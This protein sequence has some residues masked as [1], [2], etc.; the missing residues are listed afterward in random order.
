MP[1]LS[2]AM[3]VKN[4]AHRLGRCLDSVKGLADEL[5]VVDT[6]STDGTVALA[7]A[8]GARI[9]HFKWCDDFAAARNEAL[10]LC[11]GTWI[12]VLDA[13]ERL[14]PA[15]LPRIRQTLR[16]PQA[17]GFLLTMRNHLPS[18]AYVG[19]HGGARPDPGGC[20]EAAGLA[21]ITEL[22]ELRLFRNHPKVRYRG[23]IH[24][25]IEPS[26]EAQGWKAVPL[27][28][29]IH[30]LGKADPTHELAKQEAYFRM[31][32]QEAEDHPS[33]RH[34]LY[35]L[36]Q[37]AAMVKAWEACAEAALGFLRLTPR[38]APLKVRLDGA[39]ALR[40]LGRFREAQ[41]LLEA[42]QPR[43]EARSALL[44]ARGD[45][46]EA[47][48]RHE[49]AAAAYLEAINLD[50]RFT[51]PFLALADLLRGQGDW[52]SAQALLQAGLDQNPKDLLLWQALVGQASA[53]GD[54]PAAGRYAWEAL[55]VFPQGG[56]GVWHGFAALA[57]IQKGAK[58]EALEVVARGLKAF[59]GHPELEALRKVLEAPA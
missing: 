14:D 12:L 57:L 19:T 21:Y 30:H 4:E 49:E 29:V 33:D 28:V 27:P 26:F 48:G 56:E 5:V 58:P 52:G 6:G 9:G 46:L 23:R 8:A 16:A 36:M 54:I 20:P 17:Q 31:A 10:R 24:E 41:E 35:N 2:L 40:E 25:M 38:N 55:A 59:P 45:L 53:A 51:A 15:A 50:P 43:P 39:R 11:T 7:E 34:A 3:I 37:E 18:G 13:D 47:Q 42:A 1:I 44:A 32:K 22:P